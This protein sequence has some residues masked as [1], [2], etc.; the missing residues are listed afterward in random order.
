MTMCGPDGDECSAWWRC[1]GSDDDVW[2]PMTMRYAWEVRGKSWE[3]IN[4]KIVH[5]LKL[6][7]RFGNVHKESQRTDEWGCGAKERWHIGVDNDAK[8]AAKLFK[9]LRRV[10][11]SSSGHFNNVTRRV[12]RDAAAELLLHPTVNNQ[13]REGGKYRKELKT[14]KWKNIGKNSKQRIQERNQNRQ[15]EKYRKELKIE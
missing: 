10:S 15:E 9:A 7:L 3:F 11:I 14:D 5:T 4:Q 2:G 1:L 6:I 8:V 13:N 12:K